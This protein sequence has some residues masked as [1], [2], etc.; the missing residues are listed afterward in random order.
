MQG[1][2]SGKGRPSWGKIGRQR[3][4]GNGAMTLEGTEMK[5]WILKGMLLTM[6]TLATMA[7][8]LPALAVTGLCATCHVM[9]A[10][11]AGAAIQ[12]AQNPP[13]SGSLA[14]IAPQD[15]LMRHTCLGCHAGA[16]TSAPNTSTNPPKVYATSGTDLAGGNFK[17]IVDSGD[18]YGHNPVELGNSDT[19]TSP[20][21]WK[22][23]FTDAASGQVGGAGTWTVDKLTCAGVWGCHGTH[24]ASGVNGAHHNNT[25]G[26]L[27]TADSVGNS[28]RFLLGIKG[29]EDADYEYTTVAAND[30]NVY[31]GEIRAADT[32]SGKDTM[33][34][35]CAE[36]HGIFHSG[37]GN[38]GTSDTG[39]TFGT[40]PWIRHPVDIAMPYT[41]G[42]ATEYDY[43]G[44]YN[45]TVPVA[46]SGD[47]S[48]AVQSSAIT[49]NTNRIV[50]C[51]SCHRA[52][53]SQYAAALRWD[54]STVN[55][56]AGSSA[57]GCFACHTAKD[58]AT[59][60]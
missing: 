58:G 28:Y 30:H 60:N 42:T 25:N 46:T 41:N 36:C 17:Y 24:T 29:G 55:A 39:D 48:A 35:L 59:G 7:S 22:S 57:T 9:H 19:L 5:G 20:P 21:G 40:D 3:L 4:L 44:T 45:V 2:G 16:S 34:Y 18:T 51:L 37:A 38:E 33:S 52:H 10:S 8:P 6:A 13:G 54:P 49:T 15:F 47:I 11:Q 32:A 53:A 23:G 31:R 26:Q 43:Y 12:E 50:M 56:G 14:D 27:N 1:A